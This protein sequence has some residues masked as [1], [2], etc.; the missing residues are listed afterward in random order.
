MRP[1]GLKEVVAEELGCLQ[2]K[3]QGVRV[4]GRE[5]GRTCEWTLRLPRRLALLLCWW[6]SRVQE[7]GLGPEAWK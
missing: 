1:A 4:G 6:S 2:P 3:N 5:P 7:G